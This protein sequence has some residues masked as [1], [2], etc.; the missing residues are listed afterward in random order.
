MARNVFKPGSGDSK[1]KV[2]EASLTLKKKMFSL[3]RLN[4]FLLNDFLEFSLQIG[5]G[6]GVEKEADPGCL[7]K[8]FLK[9]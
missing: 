2:I 3:N 5:Y 9:F 4:D 8:R 6:G 7:K 1:R